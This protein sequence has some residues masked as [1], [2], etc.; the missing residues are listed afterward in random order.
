MRFW[1]WTPDATVPVESQSAPDA[2]M[3]DVQADCAMADALALDMSTDPDRRAAQTAADSHTKISLLTPTKLR[4]RLVQ[5][6][7]ELGNFKRQK[8]SDGRKIA[9]LQCDNNA[10]RQHVNDIAT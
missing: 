3:P 1:R 9:A 5:T 8:R 10:L 7:A 2:S 6:A 4:Q